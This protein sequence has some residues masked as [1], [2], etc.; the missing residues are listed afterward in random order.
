MIAAEP[1]KRPHA[2]TVRIMARAAGRTQ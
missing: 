2:H 1:T